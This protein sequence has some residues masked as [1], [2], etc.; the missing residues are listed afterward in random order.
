MSRKPDPD[1]QAYRDAMGK[2][3]PQPDPEHPLAWQWDYRGRKDQRDQ[4]EAWLAGETAEK[5]GAPEVSDD[6]DPL[7]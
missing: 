1:E 7:F 4:F 5:P 6:Q 2:D 3:P